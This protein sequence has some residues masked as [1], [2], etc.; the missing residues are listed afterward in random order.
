MTVCI[1]GIG[2]LDRDIIAVSDQRLTYTYLSADSSTTMKVYGL[3]RHWMAMFSGNDIGNV[4]PILER[5]KREVAAHP[6]ATT[7]V[8]VARQFRNAYKAHRTTLIEERVL[9]HLGMSLAEFRKTGFDQLGPSAF[10]DLRHK[11]EATKVDCDFLVCGFSDD[12]TPQLFVISD[13]GLSYYDTAGFWAIGEGAYSAISSLAFRQYH[14]ALSR[15]ESLY[16]L[17]EAKFM[18]ES[19]PSVGRGTTVIALNVD[20]GGTIYSEG[21]IETVREI[22]MNDGRPRMPDDL[23]NRIPKGSTGRSHGQSSSATISSK[24]HT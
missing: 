12:K 19:S 11:V 8:E 9:A 2:A 17:L 15:E 10:E 20:G 5:V 6:D 21:D 24:D 14:R 13:T 22:W 1:A 7:R 23:T 3:H 18:A 16:L 4:K